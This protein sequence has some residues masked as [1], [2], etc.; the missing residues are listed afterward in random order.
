MNGEHMASTRATTIEAYNITEAAR[1]VGVTRM[2]LHRAIN[3]G[4]LV[5]HPTG[6]RSRII[7][8]ADLLE[9]VLRYRQGKGI[10]QQ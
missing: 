9:Y 8:A 3:D 1:L 4:R 10:E 5:A 7:Y 2:T 6:R